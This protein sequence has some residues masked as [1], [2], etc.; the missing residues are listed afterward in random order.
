MP[1]P[2]TPTLSSAN[3]AS[4]QRYRVALPCRDA[5]YLLTRQENCNRGTK[6]AALRPHDQT[7]RQSHLAD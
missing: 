7:S 1:G 3:L 5:A 4:N 2:S 6:L